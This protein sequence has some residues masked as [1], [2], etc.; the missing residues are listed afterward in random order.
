VLSLPWAAAQSQPD[1]SGRWVLVRA[2]PADAPAAGTLV[3]R[4]PIVRA[5]VY[6]EP[7]QPFFK[8][9]TIERQFVDLTQIQTY[10]IGVTGGTVGGI[11]AGHDPLASVPETRFFVRWEDN[12]LVI[13]TGS[14]A[15]SSRAAG[16]YTERTETWRLDEAGLLTVAVTD[17]RSDTGSTTSFATYRRP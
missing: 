7:T 4:Q 6:G 5:N 17:R 11:A 2:D 10:D 16:P 9:I 13:D 3:V 8:A 14:Y 12:R 1:F 15:G